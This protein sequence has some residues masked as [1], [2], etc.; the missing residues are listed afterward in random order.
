MTENTNYPATVNISYHSPYGVHVQ[1]L[2]TKAWEAGIGSGDQGGYLNWVGAPIDADTMIQAFV[3]AQADMFNSSVVFDSYTIYSYDTPTGIG[4]P[5]ASNVLAIPG[6]IGVSSWFAAVQHT[7]NMIDDHFNRVKIVLLDV[8]SGGDFGKVLP[9]AL[10]A[11]QLALIAEFTD[12]E[13]A[14][15]SKAN[16]V[17]YRCDNITKTINDK[18]RA[19][20]NIA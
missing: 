20:Y 14:W 10:T 17:P 16:F 12:L 5:V 13:N 8:V 18:L 15:S 4:H 11:E 9:A 7:F 19:E 2:K 6:T 1:T 3:T